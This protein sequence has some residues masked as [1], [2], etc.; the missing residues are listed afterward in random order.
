MRKIIVE[1]E[2]SV[3]GAMGGENADFWKQVFPY[4]SPDVRRISPISD[5]HPIRYSWVGKP[6]SSLRWFGQ[7]VRERMQTG[8]ITC[9]STLRRRH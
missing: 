1:A 2:V 9:R 5:S 8:Y 7:L 4:H 6:M 3:D